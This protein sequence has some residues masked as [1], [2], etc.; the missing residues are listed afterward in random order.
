MTKKIV[1][2][3]YTVDIKGNIKYPEPPPKPEVEDKGIIDVS[4]DSLLRKGLET[5]Y[6]IMKS[7]REEAKSM[8]PSRASVMN[9]KDCM[10]MLKDL[11]AQEDALLDGMTD[12]QIEEYLKSKK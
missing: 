3:P 12:E 7:C 6:L 5:I 9:L 11:K 8:A 10:G 4:I 1:E 2:G